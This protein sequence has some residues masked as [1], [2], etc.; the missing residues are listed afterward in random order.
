MSCTSSGNLANREWFQDAKFGL[1]IHWGVYSLLARGEWVLHNDGMTLDQYKAL[2]G[3]FNPYLFNATAWVLMA[4]N[5]GMRYVR[6]RDT[7]CDD[8]LLFAC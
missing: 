1:F 8:T 4:K 7:L 6:P 5:A 2:P 3:Q